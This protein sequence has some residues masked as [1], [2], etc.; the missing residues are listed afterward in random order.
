MSQPPAG[1][2]GFSLS[3]GGLA[4][5]PAVRAPAAGSDKGGPSGGGPVREE[6]LGFGADGGLRTAA[7]AAA[8]RGPLVIAPQ[9]N[10]YK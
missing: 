5:K 3:L 9:E 8:A 10:S 2:G 1:G 4:R 7:P 6:V